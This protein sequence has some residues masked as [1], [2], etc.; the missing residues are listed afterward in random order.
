MNEGG[1]FAAF[2]HSGCRFS[3]LV[4]CHGWV[5]LVCPAQNAP[6]QVTNLGKALLLKISLNARRAPA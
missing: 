4:L 5:D 6:D 3:W 2:V 1:A